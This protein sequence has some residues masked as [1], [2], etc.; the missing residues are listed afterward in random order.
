MQHQKRELLSAATAVF[1]ILPV[2]PTVFLFRGDFTEPE[3]NRKAVLKVRWLRLIL[4]LRN[5][6]AAGTI[7]CNYDI[8]F[9]HWYPLLTDYCLSGILSLLS[10][11]LLPSE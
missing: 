3:A 8:T 9:K 4:H 7:T 2:Y 1:Y 6:H 11:V 5:I 10:F